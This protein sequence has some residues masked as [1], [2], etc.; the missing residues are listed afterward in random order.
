VSRL[1]ESL[2]F[3]YGLSAGLGWDVGGGSAG[4]LLG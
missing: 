3:E 1:G 2:V 4:G